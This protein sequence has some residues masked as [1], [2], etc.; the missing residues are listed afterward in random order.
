MKKELIIVFFLL[1]LSFSLFSSQSDKVTY[2]QT[3]TISF[4]QTLNSI[5]EPG[6]NRLIEKYAVS[7]LVPYNKQFLTAAIVF[8]VVSGV[9]LV[10]G[11]V[12][13]VLWAI[14]WY[15][16]VTDFNYNTNVPLVWAGSALMGVGWALF[17]ITILG[18]IAFWILYGLSGGPKGAM[19]NIRIE[20]TTVSI[21]L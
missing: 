21:K 4:V 14:G 20:G 9:L 19:K 18:V 16:P 7:A 10:M 1:I 3:E 13:S 6:I 17:S 15:G 2:N 8:T 11:I 5:S 12:G